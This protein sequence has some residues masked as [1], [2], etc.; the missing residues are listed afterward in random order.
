M[1]PGRARLSSKDTFSMSTQEAVSSLSTEAVKGT[2]TTSRRWKN[3]KRLASSQVS[4]PK[5]QLLLIIVSKE[6]LDQ[7]MYI[8]ASSISIILF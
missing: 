4:Q 8:K 7:T 5:V 1:S 2:P 6:F 3:A